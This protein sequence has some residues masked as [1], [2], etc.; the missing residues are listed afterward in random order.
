MS[1]EHRT[2]VFVSKPGV[3][4]AGCEC[5]WQSLPYD[6]RSRAKREAGAHLGQAKLER[7]ESPWAREEREAEG[8]R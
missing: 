1:E 7:Q 4:H 5:A 6:N 3:F 8:G 2:F